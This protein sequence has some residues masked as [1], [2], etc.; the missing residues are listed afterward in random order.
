MTKIAIL[1]NS[2]AAS[3]FSMIG[4]GSLLIEAAR[5]GGFEVVEWRGVS[6]FSRLPFTGQLLKLARNMDRFILTPLK[7]LGRKADLVHVVDPGNCIYL[8]L[9]SHRQSVV[10]VHDMIPWLARDK[11]LVGFT[12]TRSGLWLMERIVAQL[13]KVNLIVC[14]SESTRKDVLEFVNVTSEKTKVVYIAVFQ[15]VE[16]SPSDACDL[17]RVRFDL[18]LHKP[19]VFHIGRNFYKNRKTI[20]KVFA[21][22]RTT[23]PETHLVLV[24]EPSADEHILADQLNLGTHMHVLPQLSVEDIT[25]L[26]STSEVLLFPSLYE[27]FGLPIVEARM[28]GT[29]VVCSN[30]GSLPEVAGPETVMAA[31]NAIDE[32]ASACVELIQCG[33]RPAPERPTQFDPLIWAEAHHKIYNQLLAE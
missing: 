12:P 21:Q 24:G 10:T 8:P 20:L 27:G 11:R 13:A 30:A 2:R 31:P 25:A 26:Y 33:Q 3:Q 23:L 5:N 15:R 4:Y 19:L 22:V 14:D 29:P 1:T 32:L 7:L 6:L 16:P 9:T 18:P 17:F 28:C